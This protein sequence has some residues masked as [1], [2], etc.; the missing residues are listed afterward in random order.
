MIPQP[1]QS[2]KLFHFPRSNISQPASLPAAIIA[3]KCRDT[4]NLDFP[5]ILENIESLVHGSRI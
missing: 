4:E 3:T 5:N 1:S 2:L